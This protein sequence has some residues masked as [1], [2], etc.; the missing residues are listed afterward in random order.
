MYCVAFLFLFF[1]RVRVFVP[2]HLYMREQAFAASGRFAVSRSEHSGDSVWRW[3]CSRMYERTLDWSHRVEMLIRTSWTNW[4][5]CWRYNG[6][7]SHLLPALTHL[8]SV[9]TALPGALV[10]SLQ[11]DTKH[12]AASL[13]HLSFLCTTLWFKKK[14]RQLWRT[15]TTIQFSRF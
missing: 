14:T 7:D 6:V 15:I 1:F 13:R 11:T 4:W 2:A 5:N 10:T 9:A 8:P 3:H 12:S